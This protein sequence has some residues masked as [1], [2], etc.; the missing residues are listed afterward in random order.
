MSRSTSPTPSCPYRETV[1]AKSS[2]ICSVQVPQQAQPYL[3]DGRAPRRGALQGHRGRCKSP[4]VTISRSA[5]VSSPTNTAGTS[6]TPGRSGAFGPDTTGPNLLVDVSKGVQYLNEIKD[7]CRCRFPVGH[8]GGC[9]RRGAHARYPIQHHGCHP[10]RRCH[11]S[12]CR[13]DH[14]DCP[15]CPVSPLT[16][17]SSPGLQEPMFLVEIQVPESAQGGVYV[18]VWGCRVSWVCRD[19]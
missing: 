13:S 1:Q 12:W 11:P 15:S 2:R 7:S 9:L 14:A 6:L 18:G 10:P 3:P 4:R 19:D 8:Q 16:L 17:L 5:P